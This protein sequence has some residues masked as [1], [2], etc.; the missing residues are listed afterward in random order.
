MSN[1]YPDKPQLAVGAIVFHE[2][3]VLLV[4]RG[5]P[6]AKDTWSIPGGSVELGETLQDAAEREIW[7]ETGIVIKAKKPVFTFDFV[8]KDNQG[9]IRYHYVIIDL[10]AEYIKGS[11]RP[12]DDV[13]DVGWFTPSQINDI[14]INAVTKEFLTEYFDFSV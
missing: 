12:G 13:V 14:H 1:L 11:I 7:E 6:P 4:K 9:K 5:N 3:K 8:D 2:G 10:Y